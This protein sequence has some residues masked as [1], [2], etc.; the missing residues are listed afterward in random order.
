MRDWIRKRPRL[1]GSV[2][3][4]AAIKLRALDGY[5]DTKE[6]KKAASHIITPDP[7]AVHSS[8]S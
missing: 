7:D 2:V 6:V 5:E 8:T 1:C 4:S 3:C